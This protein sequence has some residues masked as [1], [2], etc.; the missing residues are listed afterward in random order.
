[1]DVL[2][3]LFL[4]LIFIIIGVILTLVLQY[5]VLFVYFKRKPVVEPPSKQPKLD[6]YALPDVSFCIVYDSYYYVSF[7]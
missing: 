4:S 5:Y 1:M 7:F 2:V 3:L 6:T